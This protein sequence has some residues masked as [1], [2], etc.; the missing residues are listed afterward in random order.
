M[1]KLF[2]IVAMMYTMAYELHSLTVRPV[3]GPPFKNIHYVGSI[4][5]IKRISEQIGH[6]LFIPSAHCRSGQDMQQGCANNGY[7]NYPHS[8]HTQTD[9]G[10]L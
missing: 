5:A 7:L 4:Q 3:K 9:G 6:C 8:K 1:L 10:S 2:F